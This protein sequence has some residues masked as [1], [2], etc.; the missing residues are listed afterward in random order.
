MDTPTPPQ[1]DKLRCN[2]VIDHVEGCKLCKTYLRSNKT[3]KYMR[4]ESQ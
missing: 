3:E 2:H 4:L 1:E